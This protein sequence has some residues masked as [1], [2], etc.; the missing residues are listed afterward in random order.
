MQVKVACAQPRSWR[1]EDERK[2]LDTALM[3]IDQAADM[4][5]QL[6]T[7][8]EGFPGPYHGPVDWSPVAAIQE[9]ARHHRIHVV[10][11]L[12]EPAPGGGYYLALKLVDADG[13]V[14]HTYYRVQPNPPEVDHVLMNK[15][16]IVPG[17]DLAVVQTDIGRIGLLIC[18]EIWNPEL[19]RVLALQ[20]A[21]IIVAPIGGLVYE[22]SETWKSVF[23]TRAIENHVYMLASQNLYGMEDGLC[24]IAGPESW[25]VTRSDPGL[26]VATLDLDRLV[27]LRSNRQSLALPKPYKS[28]PGLLRYRRPE[29]YTILTAPQPDAYDFW[30]YRRGHDRSI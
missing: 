24:M 3:F 12:V 30:Y 29:K 20:G 14:R 17:E 18:S 16:T 2:N 25:L 1:G 8:P 19:V 4:N 22:L 5:A 7:F 21:E 11:G 10:F 13:E 27:W 15:K 9:R 23:W 6:V 28:I 26:A